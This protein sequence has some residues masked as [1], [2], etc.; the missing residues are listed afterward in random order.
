MKTCKKCGYNFPFIVKID[1]KDR[2]LQRRNLCLN[3]L[4]FGERQ[5]NG[6]SINQDSPKIVVRECK[7]HGRIDF[8]LQQSGYRCKKCR[9]ES[10]SKN[11][12][13]RKLR[14]A[15]ALGGKCCLCGYNKCMDAL[16]FH[17][18]DPTQKSFGIS[19]K[20]VT[21]AFTRALEEAKKC[22]LVCANCHREIE[23][24]IT[25]IDH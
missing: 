4:P 11:R 2:N 12:R 19:H 22:V 16:D 7:H 21:I 1:G 18:V 23:A 6:N 10:V 3:C 13:S 20:G 25:K 5:R 8:V 9:S 24:G 15:K 17:H 14:L